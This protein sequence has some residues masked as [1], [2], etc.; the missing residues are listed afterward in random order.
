MA[1][2]AISIEEPPILVNL[3]R[4]IDVEFMTIMT[5]SELKIKLLAVF[6]IAKISVCKVSTYGGQGLRV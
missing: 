4:V 6:N 5:N 2:Q 3:S 1:E